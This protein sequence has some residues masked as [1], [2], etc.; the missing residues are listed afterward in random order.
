MRKG[1]IYG[2]YGDNDN[3]NSVAFSLGIEALGKNLQVV[4]ISF[5]EFTSSMEKELIKKFEPDFRIFQFTK[6][7]DQLMEKVAL[8]DITDEINQAFHF[9]KKVVDTGECD[10]LI[11]DGI[12]DV[13]EKGYLEPNI[14][15]EI[16]DKKEEYMDIILTGKNLSME[17]EG[18]INSIYKLV[19]EK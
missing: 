3:L 14:I 7:Q 16:L 11:L 17:L 13:I 5:L 9:T 4:M 8:K 15:L 1:N 19:K 2:Y 18:K 10:V 12:F 6:K